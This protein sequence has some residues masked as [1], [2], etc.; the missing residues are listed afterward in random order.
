MRNCMQRGSLVRWLAGILTV[1]L[2]LPAYAHIGAGE[3]SGILHGIAHPLTGADHIAAMVAVGLWAIQCGGRATWVVPLSFVTVMSATSLAGAAGLSLPFVEP[4]IAASVL[5]F[6][7]LIAAA[8]RLPLAASTVLVALF[9]I[10]H[11]H[12]HGAEMPATAAGAAYGLGFILSTALLHGTGIVIG[13][14]AGKAGS[15]HLIRYA[16]GATAA[17]GVYLVI[18]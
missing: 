6:G 15:P 2:P 1:L 12:A 5:V 3:A 8:V 9:A 18:T 17:F 11:G 16:G 7:L 13:M 4:G 14:L 10:F